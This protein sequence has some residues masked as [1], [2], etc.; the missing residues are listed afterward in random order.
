VAV[1]IG[2]VY[3]LVL[4]NYLDIKPHPQNFLSQ[5]IATV[6]A[7]LILAGAG[8]LRIPRWTF[9]A[10]AV[11]LAVAV[12]AATNILMAHLTIPLFQIVRFSL[13]LA[14]AL[15]VGTLVGIIAAFRGSRFSGDVAMALI[16]GCGL[17]QLGNAPRTLPNPPEPHHIIKLDAKLQ[18]ACTGQYEFPPDNVFRMGAGVKIWREEERIFLQATGRRV[19]QGAHEIF[20]ESETNFFLPINSAELTFIKND[21][22]EVTGLIHHMTGLPDSEAKKVNDSDR[23]K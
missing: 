1:I 21:K 2:S 23:Q 4:N 17:F 8:K 15:V 14:P 10:L 6:I 16:I 12:V 19:L 13:I 20:S 9:A 7:W 5:I 22:G 18:D 11:V 3:Y